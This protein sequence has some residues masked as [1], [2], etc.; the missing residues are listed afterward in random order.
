MLGI[1]LTEK[2]IILLQSLQSKEIILKRKRKKEKG[3]KGGT[4][5]KV[6]QREKEKKRKKK[7]KFFPKCNSISLA[8]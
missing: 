1:A 5:G 2:T 3:E 7:I 4:R 8:K 6:R